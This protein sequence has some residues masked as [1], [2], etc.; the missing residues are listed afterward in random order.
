MC[1]SGGGLSRGVRPERG[2]LTS[3]KILGKVEIQ[4]KELLFRNEISS[5]KNDK[6]QKHHTGFAQ[7][8][9]FEHG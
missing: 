1:F 5:M 4:K 8:T 3:V 7:A 9:L 2:E 6:Q